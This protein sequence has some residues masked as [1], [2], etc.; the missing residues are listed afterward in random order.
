MKQKI[1]IITAC[2]K[3][4]GAEKVARDIALYGDCSQ[5]EYH[6]VVFRDEIG[7][8]EPQLLAL[9]CRIFHLDPPGKSYP[10]YLTALASLIRE[11]R[12]H[13]VH[14]HTMFSSGWPM[15]AAKLLGVPVRIVHAHSALNDGRSPA[16]TLY[17]QFMR[18]VI[19]SCATD[20]VA[21]GEKAGIRLFGEKAFR[22]RGD[23]I[24]N[25]IDLNAFQFCPDARKNLRRSLGMED[26]FILGHAGHLAP[27]KNQRFLL[28]LMPLLL[29]RIPNAK[30]LL[31]G[32]GPD[33]EMLERRIRELSL[34]EHVR[35]TGNVL[36]VS[37][38]LSAMDVFVFPSL[39]EGTPLTILEVQTNGLP[40]VLSTGVPQDVF[41]TDLIHPLPLDAPQTRWVDSI[42]AV[43]R[44]SSQRYFHQ[45][46]ALGL[47]IRSAVAKIHRIYGGN[48]S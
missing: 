48:A 13:A 27:V 35:M 12:Y 45:M 15:L 21:C 34:E 24:L 2:L 28:E 37:D 32:A 41:L 6:Y 47:D 17:E 14:V 46:N 40:C 18:V 1:L 25:G 16:K 42:C 4:G 10:A 31:L 26:C 38:Y 11:H 44:Q 5:Y 7:T 20:L 19:L 22:K 9:G 39:Y 30:L 23:L 36:N 43:H 8:Y 29:Q 3:I 33:Q